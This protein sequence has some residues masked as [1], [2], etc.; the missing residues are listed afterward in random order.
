MHLENKAWHRNKME[1]SNRYVGSKHSHQILLQIAAVFMQLNSRSKMWKMRRKI[2]HCAHSLVLCTRACSENKQN[3][4]KVIKSALQRQTSSLIPFFCFV[5]LRWDLSD[6]M[7][8][9]PHQWQ[10]GWSLWSSGTTPNLS[11]SMVTLPWS[12]SKRS[13]K[14]SSS[15]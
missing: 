15:M 12:W 4:R 3:Y 9:T 14:L 13:G 2:I 10:S 1:I 11:L 5:Y 7:A 6:T 8:T